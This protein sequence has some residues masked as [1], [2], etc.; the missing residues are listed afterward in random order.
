VAILKPSAHYGTASHILVN[1][2]RAT[3]LD[4]TVRQSVTV[5]FAGFE[6]ETHGGLTRPS[7]GRVKA[8]YPRGT[9]IRNTRQITIVSQEELDEIA[10]TM[11]VAVVK[12]E[13]VGANL[14]VVG[15][16]NFTKTPPSSRIIFDNDVSLVVDMENGPC[17]HPGKVI[18]QHAENDVLVPFAKAALG[19]RGVTAWVERPGTL[20]LG[21]RCRLHVPI[22]TA[23]NT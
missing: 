23:Q 21:E 13:W 8:Q 10:T 9:E 17:V 2:D 4:S 18:A 7:C 15:I 14:V 20:T 5:T 16:P 6:G 22:A 12:P 1:E 19:K 11:G 3:G